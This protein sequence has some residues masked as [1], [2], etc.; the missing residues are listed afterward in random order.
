MVEL[1]RGE[2]WHIGV[3]R[4]IV[5]EFKP[6]QKLPLFPWARNYTLIASSKYL[7]VRGTDLR[8]I[9]ISKKCFFH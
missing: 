6:H 3:T 8:V 7:F 9:Y 2:V 5:I 4:L 1:K